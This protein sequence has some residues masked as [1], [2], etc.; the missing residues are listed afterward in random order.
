MTW[1]SLIEN[2]R[3]IISL[4]KRECRMKG[5]GFSP[6]PCLANVPILKWVEIELSRPLKNPCL[7][8]TVMTHNEPV[9]FCTKPFRQN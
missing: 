7:A 3:R 2:E 5:L 6:K 8:Y 4:D 9:Q 1:G